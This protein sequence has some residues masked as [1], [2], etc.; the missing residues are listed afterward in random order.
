MTEME[1]EV[2]FCGASQIRPFSG[3][4][5]PQLSY[6]V[7]SNLHMIKR[8]TCYRN[9]NVPS[10]CVYIHLSTSAY[11]FVFITCANT[12][13]SSTVGTEE[14]TQLGKGLLYTYENQVTP[15][16][17]C[18][19]A[20]LVELVIPVL[21]RGRQ[22]GLWGLLASQASLT[23]GFQPVRSSLRTRWPSLEEGT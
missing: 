7:C 22:A 20:G 18:R 6:K 17:P 10:P 4:E 9:G 8:T 12:C 15:Q 2:S 11:P 21:E 3:I 1:P 19:E 23:N 5:S 13:W 16:H 14:M